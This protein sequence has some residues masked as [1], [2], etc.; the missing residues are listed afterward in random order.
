MLGIDDPLVLLAFLGCI[1]ATAL[2]VVYGLMRRNAAPDELT[3]EDRA[4]AVEEKKVED[5]I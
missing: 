4:W 3:Q 1:A 2:S 5:E